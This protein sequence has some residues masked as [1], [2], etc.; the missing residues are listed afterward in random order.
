MKIRLQEVKELVGKEWRWEGWRTGCSAAFIYLWVRSVYILGHG[1]P[2]LQIRKNS[3]YHREGTL[4]KHVHVPRRVLLQGPRGLVT[5]QPSSVFCDQMAFGQNSSVSLS[6]LIY[7][8]SFWFY[9]KKFF[10]PLRIAEWLELNSVYKVTN[11]SARK[12]KCY[13]SPLPF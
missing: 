6:F 3:L 9:L 1:F 4:C 2:S 11:T 7:K 13:I 5:K 10:P 12:S 8:K